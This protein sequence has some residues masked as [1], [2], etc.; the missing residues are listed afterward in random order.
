VNTARRFCVGEVRL[1]RDGYRE[2]KEKKEKKRKE[3]KKKEGY[4]H[5]E[6]DQ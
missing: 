4:L 5:D 6:L 1:R 2:E 3:K